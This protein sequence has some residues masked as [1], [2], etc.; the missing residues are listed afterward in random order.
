MKRSF[1]IYAGSLAAF[2]SPGIAIVEE[3]PRQTGDLTGGVVNLPIETQTRILRQHADQSDRLV[4]TLYGHSGSGS[5][6][7]AGRVW[8]EAASFSP[9]PR[10][11]SPRSTPG[12]R[13]ANVVLVDSAVALAEIRS[14]LSL[15]IKE[16]AE[17][18]GVQRPT[19][20]SWLDG[21]QKPQAANQKKLVTLLQIARFWFSQS[22]QPIGKAIRQ[23]INGDGE[24]LVG[25]LKKSRVNE[26]A[27]RLHMQAIA[28]GLAATEPKRLSILELAKQKGMDVSGVKSQRDMI[29]SFTG[30]RIQE[31]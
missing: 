16:L 12:N 10:K 17:I 22:D 5:R 20:Y 25:Q 23:E 31:D 14:G 11:T 30:K 21:K 26:T 27:V 1:P 3:M 13:S 28:D 19:I 29:D 18:L 24:T 15:Q 2:S 9:E 6:S 8:F 4:Q 7:Q